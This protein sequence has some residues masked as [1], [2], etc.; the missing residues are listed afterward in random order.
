MDDTLMQIPARFR[1]KAGLT[2]EPRVARKFAFVLPRRTSQASKKNDEGA[3]SSTKVCFRITE[4]NKS[5]FEEE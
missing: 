1:L 3:E 4:A 2:K 5:S